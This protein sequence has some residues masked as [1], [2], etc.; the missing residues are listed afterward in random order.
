MT[1][2]RILDLLQRYTVFISSSGFSSIIG[3]AT[4][5]STRAE[6]KYGIMGV[7]WLFFK[8]VEIKGLA[9]THF[10]QEFL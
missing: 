2:V 7:M 1:V 9:L 4:V 5:R 6:A 10:F 8:K 3:S